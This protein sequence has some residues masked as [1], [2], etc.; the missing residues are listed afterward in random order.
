MI[1]YC[2]KAFFVSSSHYIIDDSY[3]EKELN[4][5]IN[6]IVGLIR[7]GLVSKQVALDYIHLYKV[8]E[9][10]GYKKEEL[11]M[12]FNSEEFSRR[13]VV[14]KIGGNKNEKENFNDSNDDNMYDIFS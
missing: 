9:I 10:K 4:L 8:T 7:E 3:S 11:L 5:A 2:V 6:N 13:Y 14:K 1:S 12:Y